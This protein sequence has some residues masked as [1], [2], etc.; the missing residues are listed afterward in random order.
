MNY[1]KNEEAQQIIERAKQDDHIFK[2]THYNSYVE[3][4]YKIES[5]TC[6]TFPQWSNVSNIV[7]KENYYYITIAVFNSEFLYDMEIALKHGFISILDKIEF[8]I[9]NKL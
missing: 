2:T 5:I 4:I 8:N 1:L 7:F 9:N 6:V 3:L